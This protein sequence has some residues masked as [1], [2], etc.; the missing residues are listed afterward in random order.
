MNVDGMLFCIIFMLRTC[1]GL[2]NFL[3]L[4]DLL[5]KPKES[6]KK[7]LNLLVITL[8]ASAF[9]LLTE[10]LLSVNVYYVMALVLV[11]WLYIEFVM[12]HFTGKRAQKLV[13]GGSYLLFNFYSGFLLLMF[14]QSIFGETLARQ[15]M[16]RGW[17]VDDLLKVAL[18]FLLLYVKKQR[19]KKE[20]DYPVHLII[21]SVFITAN[22]LALAVL[23]LMKGELIILL[24]IAFL[25]LLFS[26]YL[27]LSKQAY[28]ENY[29]YQV[30]EQ[31]QQLMKEHYQKV[32]DFHDEIQQ[33]HHK[34]TMQ[35]LT[36]QKLIDRNEFSQMQTQL[37][38][39]IEENISI[40]YQW[41]TSHKEMNVLIGYKYRQA[42]AAGIN[43][44]SQIN[45]PM[46]LAIS[47]IDLISLVSNLLDNAIEACTYCLPEESWIK[48]QMAAQKQCL[49]IRVEN[50]TDNVHQSFATRKSD[51]QQHGIGL[52]SV[53]RIVKK[54]NG[55]LEYDWQKHSFSIEITLFMGF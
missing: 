43:F 15:L 30:K 38:G 25:L 14:V 36:M 24:P 29:H 3:M 37:S 42:Q 40:D 41:F 47:E 54:Y 45:I 20:Y 19:V 11:S 12:V 4:A 10:H 53:Q 22:C 16:D 35:L 5:F 31:K 28:K 33:L 39:L 52:K 26:S 1:L 9:T 34:M 18:F 21:L 13:I 17:L 27:K 48:F 23:F 51:K 6:V 46:S 50:S 32:D 55:E 2:V 49:V 8:I 44:Q 7:P